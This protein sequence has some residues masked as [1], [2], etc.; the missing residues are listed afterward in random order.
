MKKALT[1]AIDATLEGTVVLSF[2]RVGYAVRS[3]LG[4]WGPLPRLDDRWVVITG[5]TSG[6]GLCAAEALAVVGANVIVIGRNEAKTRGVCDDILSRHRGA[7]VIP[8]IADTGSLDDVRQA[9]TKIAT[10][11]DTL[12]AL[13]H[14]AGAIAPQF[15]TNAEGLEVT[16][17]SQL[18][19]P[20]LLTTLLTPLLVKAAPG[21]V[22]T[23]SSGGMYSWKFDLADMVMTAANFDGVKAYARVK[24]AQVVL[25]HE[26]ALRHN[27]RDLLFASTHPGWS[28]TPGLA[29]S[30]PGFHC[31]LRRWLR[32]PAEGVDTLLWLV[33]TPTLARHDGQFFLDR[34]PR[35]EYKMPRTRATSPSQDQR[36]LYDWCVEQTA[37]SSP[38][39]PQ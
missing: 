36:S 7:R 28:D 19:G 8:V 12:H 3:R 27:P 11:T 34:R 23:M 31:F 30:L 17:A 2:S 35:G 13:I 9:A 25:T 5:A 10:F 16:V 21:R 32:T 14:N 37:V 38:D 6:L 1:R 18:T 39:V 20:F 15:T 26:Q 29:Q 4:Q 22:L 33:S 24:R